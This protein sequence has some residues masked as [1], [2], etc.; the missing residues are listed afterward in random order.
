MYNR[1]APIGLELVRSVLVVVQRLCGI[2]KVVDDHYIRN[3][4]SLG[5][6]P[7]A[8]E[9][10]TLL[11][12]SSRIA[13]TPGW[14]DYALRALLGCIEVAP[15]LPESQQS[16]VRETLAP[17]WARMREDLLCESSR[18]NRNAV[19]LRPVS[20][21]TR[22]AVQQRYTRQCASI[23]TNFANLRKSTT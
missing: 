5:S 19:T 10:A 3:K 1:P 8:E 11:D 17:V 18:L 16:F 13:A 22:R 23:S 14:L 6:G 15:D 21:H 9:V 2:L 20:G 4:L 7:I 12:D